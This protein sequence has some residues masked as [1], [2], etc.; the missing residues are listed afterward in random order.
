MELFSGKRLA[1]Q[2]KM[3]FVFRIFSGSNKPVVAW[4][5]C[6]ACACA[7]PTGF[8]SRHD[9]DQFPLTI[10]NM[11]IIT[12]C[13][14]RNYLPVVIDRIMVRRKIFGIRKWDFSNRRRRTIFNIEM[15]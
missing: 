14:R 2:C 7:V 15:E 5:Q 10:E 3:S 1:D 12:G 4:W 6:T 8:D 11:D 9:P 13:L